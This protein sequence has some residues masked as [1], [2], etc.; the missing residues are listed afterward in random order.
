LFSV[1]ARYETV[2][3]NLLISTIV[4]IQK[5]RGTAPSSVQGKVFDYIIIERNQDEFMYC[6]F[7]FSF[8]SKTY[9]NI[10]SMVLKEP[11]AYYTRNDIAAFG[12]F[13]TFLD[14][15]KAFGSLTSGVKSKAREPT[16]PL[17]CVAPHT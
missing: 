15:T 3:D 14:S 11:T 12:E 7:Q 4:P 8:K 10:C 6:E 2:A 17:M 5:V 1:T 16:N 9:V 13:C